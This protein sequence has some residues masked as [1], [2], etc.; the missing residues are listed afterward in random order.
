MDPNCNEVTIERLEKVSVAF[1]FFFSFFDQ[2]F[3]VL[4]DKC[5][6]PTDFSVARPSLSTCISH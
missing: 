3:G 2:Q 1:F 6:L 5:N 4:K